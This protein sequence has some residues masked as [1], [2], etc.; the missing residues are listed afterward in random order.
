[1]RL[2]DHLFYQA[3]E[4]NSLEC[5]EALLIAGADPRIMAFDYRDPLTS[6]L[7]C[8]GDERIEIFKCLYEMGDYRKDRVDP[9]FVTLLH[10]AFAANKKC[11]NLKIVKFLIENGEDIHAKEGKSRY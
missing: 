3:V 5:V 4:I 2:I 6:I 8:Y 7:H 9:Y 1:M 11:I 10:K